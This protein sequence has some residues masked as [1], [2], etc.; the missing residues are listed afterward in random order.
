[1]FSLHI[2]CHHGGNWPCWT[3]CFCLYRVQLHKDQKLN[4]DLK[5]LLVSDLVEMQDVRSW[6]CL[7]WKISLLPLCESWRDKMYGH[8]ISRF[9]EGPGF[10]QILEFLLDFEKLALLPRFLLYN[11]RKIKPFLSTEETKC[12]FSRISPGDWTTANCL[13]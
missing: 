13:G 4:H 9:K 8:F 3:N 5:P 6:R 11:I 7:R 12:L 10:G 2:P 1:M